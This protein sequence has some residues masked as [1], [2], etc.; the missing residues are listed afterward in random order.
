[1]NVA[2]LGASPKTERY[3]NKAIKLLVD[4]GHTVFPINPIHESIENLKTVKKPSDLKK[5]G[6][7][8]LT[9]YV[10]PNNISPLIDDIIDLNPHR[11]ILNPG[12]ESEELKQ[13]LNK[14]NINYLEACTLV[15]LKTNQFED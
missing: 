6:I 2:V 8:T 15:M 3:S 11:I 12:T 10:G 5:M 1:M 4:K 13:A 14:A 9:V 7:H